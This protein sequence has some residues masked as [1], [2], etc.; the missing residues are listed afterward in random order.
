MFE[1]SQ[2]IIAAN[3]EN[4]WIIRIITFFIFIPVYKNKIIICPPSTLICKCKEIL[5]REVFIGG[6]TVTKMRQAL[7]PELSAAMLYRS[8]ARYVILG[9]SERRSIF[10]ESNKLIFNKLLCA[11][12]FNLV[13]IL[14]VGET[15]E[16]KNQGEAKKIIKGQLVQC[17]PKDIDFENLIIAYEPVWAIG[18]GLFPKSM[19]LQKFID[20]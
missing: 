12:K 6:Q 1:K 7:R 5:P 2:K 15:L 17:I 18:T 11:T 10:K 9:H 19:I 4:E 20:L 16:E 13:P 8:G 14:C 3:L